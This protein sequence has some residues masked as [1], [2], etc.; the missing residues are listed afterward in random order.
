MSDS[1]LRIDK[2]EGA[3]LH[4]EELSSS[5][6][7][8]EIHMDSAP[9]WTPGQACPVVFKEEGAWREA[10]Y[11]PASAQRAEFFAAAGKSPGLSSLQVGDPV[12]VGA[13]A[14]KFTLE[15]CERGHL[16]FVGA[17]TG[18]APCRAMLQEL[19]RRA[20]EGLAV[21]STTLL[22][23]GAHQPQELAFAA[24]LKTMVDKQAFRLVHL[25]C[26]SAENA[27]TAIDGAHHARGRADEVLAALLQ[28]DAPR[29]GSTTAFPSKWDTDAL[30]ALLPPED[31]SIF[32][33]GYPGMIDR[34]E[35]ICRGTQWQ[36]SLVFDR[37][38]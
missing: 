37:W 28:L 3:V 25:P 35:E 7:L 12:W 17:G 5:H 27:D 15:R 36:D 20:Q 38:W 21:P 34:F 2:M 9:H 31:T 23:Q 24:S 19:E 33:C 11:A 32:L 13:G 16:V 4:R 26:V 1:D 18:V 29:V 10:W 6:V 22:V 30:R 8:L 14:G